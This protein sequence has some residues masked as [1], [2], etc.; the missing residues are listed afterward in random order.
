MST[1]EK[2]TGF[3]VVRTARSMKKSLDNNL[4]EFGITSPQHHVLS[5][6]NDEDGQALSVIGK[7]VFLDKPAMTGLADRMENDKLVERRRYPED[8]RVIKLFLT[9]SGKDIL[10]KYEHIVKETDDNLVKVLSEEELA[11]FRKMLDRIWSNAYQTD[12][13]GK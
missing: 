12:K 10:K 5:V 6:L 3:L 4:A 7:K 2:S 11:I 8:R 9:K 13:N 1:I